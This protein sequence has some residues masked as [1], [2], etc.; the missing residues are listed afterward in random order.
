MFSITQQTDD[1]LKMVDR[2][3]GRKNVHETAA[4]ALPCLALCWHQLKC[5]RFW[6]QCNANNTTGGKRNSLY[7]APDADT[8]AC[9][10]CRATPICPPVAAL[11][12]ARAA[13]HRQRK[14]RNAPATTAHMQRTTPMMRPGSG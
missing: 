12:P 1:I 11:R 3:R 9:V 10:L 13:A 5:P 8:R 4:V 14:H 7:T 2:G 6:A